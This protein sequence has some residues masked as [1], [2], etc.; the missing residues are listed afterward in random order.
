MLSRDFVRLSPSEVVGGVV[1]G[2]GSA[3]DRLGCEELV[4]R[5]PYQLVVSEIDKARL[6]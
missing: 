5:F 2:C 4:G 6:W 1:L 3:D